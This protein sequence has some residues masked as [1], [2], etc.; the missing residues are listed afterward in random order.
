[1]FLLIVLCIVFI[2]VYL[3]PFTKKT[4]HVD[5]S[6]VYKYSGLNPELYSEFLQN[7]KYMEDNLKYTDVAAGHLYKAIENIQAMSLYATGSH[8]YVIDDIQVISRQI[9]V[10]GE[11]LVLDQAMLYGNE[12]R[13]QYLNNLDV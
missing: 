4:G 2:V 7:I 1:M 8:T 6:R 13:P 9:G 12:F 11:K 10:D 5:T 3:S